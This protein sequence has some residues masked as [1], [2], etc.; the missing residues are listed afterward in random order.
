M[1]GDGVGENQGEGF[2]PWTVARVQDSILQTES[3]M[4]L[5]A[6]VQ[7]VEHVND[8]G[9]VVEY[10]ATDRTERS[11]YTLPGGTLVYTTKFFRHPTQAT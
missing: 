11:W 3:W 1:E 10:T 2:F 9:S 5:G 6:V 4:G 8:A 7:R